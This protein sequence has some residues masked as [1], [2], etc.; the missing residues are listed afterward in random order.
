MFAFRKHDFH[1]KPVGLRELKWENILKSVFY[2]PK[3]SLNEPQTF[4][5]SKLNFF[6]AYT[7]KGLKKTLFATFNQ[8]KA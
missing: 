1:W 3:L 4:F 5:F 7:E 2:D 8:S 6:V